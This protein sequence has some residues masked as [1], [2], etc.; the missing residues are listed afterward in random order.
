MLG[1]DSKGSVTVQ[2]GLGVIGARSGG[3]SW[4]D[5][6]APGSKSGALEVKRTS[7]KPGKASLQAETRLVPG[8]LRVQ[9]ILDPTEETSPIGRWHRTEQ[10]LF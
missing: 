7:S 4:R 5:S 10:T 1:E 6:L 2:E 3:T 8:A 9:G